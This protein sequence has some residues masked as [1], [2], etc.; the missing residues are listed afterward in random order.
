VR[1]VGESPGYSVVGTERR[2]WGANWWDRAGRQIIDEFAVVDPVYRPVVSKDTVDDLVAGNGGA[3]A[4]EFL[5]RRHRS[6]R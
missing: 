5:A 6:P 1:R 2:S 4:F 3:A